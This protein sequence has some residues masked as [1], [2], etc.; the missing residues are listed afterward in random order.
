MQKKYITLLLVAILAA[1]IIFLTTTQK[2]KSLVKMTGEKLQQIKDSLKYYTPTQLGNVVNI[3]EALKRQGVSADTMPFLL[4]QVAFETGHFKN[5]GARL[6]N[7]FSGIRYFGQKGATAGT[8]APKNEG[9]APYAHYATPDD[10]A[11]DYIRILTRVGKAR[12]LE[13]KT[14]EQFAHALK[15]NGYYTASESQYAAG[16]RNLY[17]NFSL[18]SKIV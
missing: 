11:K 17:K 14:P 18:L 15:L 9:A 3:A 12:P 13:A 8:P 1:L 10:W 7:N 16:I 4:A 5:A 6:D 2:G